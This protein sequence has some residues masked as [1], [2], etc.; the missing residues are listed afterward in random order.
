M[1]GEAADAAS[2]G[3][4]GVETLVDEGPRED[5]ARPCTADSLKV[6]SEVTLSR[7]KAALLELATAETTRAFRERAVDA[8]EGDAGSI[9][10]LEVALRGA[11]VIEVFSPKRSTTL[12]P[13]LGLRPVIM[14]SGHV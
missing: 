14:R 7:G 3:A 5:E 10:A 13:K 4:V 12:A 2:G 9:A 6:S 1:A 8:T 11:A